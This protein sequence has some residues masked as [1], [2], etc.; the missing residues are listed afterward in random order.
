MILLITLSS[1]LGPRKSRDPRRFLAALVTIENETRCK[2]G[3]HYA[4]RVR[5]NSHG[6]LL[7]R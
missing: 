5:L 1:F 7:V 2:D 6:S 4:G 3:F